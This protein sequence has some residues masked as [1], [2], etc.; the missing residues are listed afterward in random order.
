MLPADH[1]TRVGAKSLLGACLTAEKRYAE[2][3]PI[4][5]EAF[6]AQSQPGM[7]SRAPARTRQRILNLY[8]AWGRADAA[9][10][11]EKSHPLPPRK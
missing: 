2:A 8:R 3:E 5:L 9:E 10:A 11:F 4:L 7:G 1:R 6:T